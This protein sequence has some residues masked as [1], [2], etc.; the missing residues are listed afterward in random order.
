MT[1]SAA[2]HRTHADK[3]R[4][5]RQ[6]VTTAATR[7]RERHPVLRHQDAI[8]ASILIACM[9][10]MILS[11]WLYYQHI[12]PWYVCIPLSAFFAGLTQ[13]I[14]H[15][16]I[17]LLYFRHQKVPYHLMLA[18]AWLCRP[19]TVSPWYRR[20]LHMH[21]H[22]HSGLATDFEEQVLTNG[23]PWGVRRLVVTADLLLSMMLRPIYMFRLTLDFLKSQ[24]THGEAG[25]RA[26]TRQHLS[27]F[28]P[29]T[30][31]YHLLLS[32]WAFYHLA[33]WM[34]GL[35]GGTPMWDDWVLQGIEVVDLLMIT[36]LLPNTLR[37]FCL[38]FITSNMHYF[39][40]IEPGN[41]MQQCQVLNK[42]WLFPFQFFCFNFGS[43]HAIH[44][45]VVRET[46][47]IRQLTAPQ[48]H[49]VMR[50][51]GI[52]FNDMGTFSRANRWGIDR[53]AN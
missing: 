26:L 34:T 45:F 46:F 29:L 3:T 14:E 25:H 20:R 37:M 36:W 1:I 8:G 16:L 15:D 24:A 43:T 4:H 49:A 19:N 52:R 47:Y 35:R 40:D 28:F 2:D 31:L 17:H 33:N 6:V 53:L 50:E 13:E 9:A 38:N 18:G 32:A 11:G 39:G 7:L 22:R 44:H 23:M 30:N 48:A 51:M 41:V 27:S 21:H 10:G 12:I 42:W 5:I